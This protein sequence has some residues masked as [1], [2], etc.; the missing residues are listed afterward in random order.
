MTCTGS[1]TC[2]WHRMSMSNITVIQ[3]ASFFFVVWLELDNA[4]FHAL[5]W[6][7]SSKAAHF[8]VMLFHASFVAIC[9]V[10]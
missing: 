10:L 6:G 2:C 9:V 7:Y 1:T 3:V 8:I 5:V 4:S